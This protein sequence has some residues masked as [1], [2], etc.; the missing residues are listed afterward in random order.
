MSSAAKRSST[1]PSPKRQKKSKCCA[2]F[3]VQ[4]MLEKKLLPLVPANTNDDYWD[5]IC[6]SCYIT[7]R[8]REAKEGDDVVACSFCSWVFHNTKEC[9]GANFPLSKNEAEWKGEKEWACFRCFA[10]A[11]AFDKILDGKVIPASKF[12]F[13][14][15]SKGRAKNVEEMHE[16]FK[17]TGLLPTWI[18]GEGETAAY[19]AQGA[20]TVV[21]GGG[22][23]ASRNK[24]LDLAAKNKQY[25][26]EMSD[27]IDRLWYSLD[28]KDFG[29]Y[30]FD[31]KKD[32]SNYKNKSDW[33]C[34]LQDANAASH[35]ATKLDLTPLEAAQLTAGVMAKNKAYLGGLHSTENEGW[36]HQKK[37]VTP[38]HFVIGDFLVIDAPNT[39]VRFDE[40]MTLKED[41]DYC[42]QVSDRA[43]V[44]RAATI[45]PEYPTCVSN[46]IR[47]AIR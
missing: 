2:D 33:Q 41:Y 8:Q 7:H 24:A 25:C 43:V 30:D 39:P 3:N 27:D 21:E 9:L 20:V 23:C 15:I 16:L 32:F 29:H 6:V 40:T 44:L 37:P 35:A 45:E 26:V 22:L 34:T 19:K 36:G 11:R 18:V 13:C 42:T 28:D 46:N 1:S 14:I 31:E 17:G 47:S 12:L 5:D 4:T 10:L 38:R